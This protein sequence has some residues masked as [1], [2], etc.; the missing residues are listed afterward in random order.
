[1]RSEIP[2]QSARD[3]ALLLEEELAL[4]DAIALHAD[5]VEQEAV[6]L[7]EL[8]RVAV[9][10]VAQPRPQRRQLGVEGDLVRG[11]RGPEGSEDVKLIE[12][13]ELDCVTRRSGAHT[14]RRQ[15]ADTRSDCARARSRSAVVA[16]ASSEAESRCN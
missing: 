14:C 10:G 2:R 7:A 3:G 16:R 1:M 4:V 5:L 12:A 6:D 11:D 8:H 9:R 15:G 13:D